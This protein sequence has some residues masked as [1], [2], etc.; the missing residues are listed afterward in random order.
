VKKDK[1]KGGTKMNTDTF[2][3]V[4]TSLFLSKTVL[5]EN[6]LQNVLQNWKESDERFA[7]FV[8]ANN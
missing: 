6:V 8:I 2:L 1:E 4:K 3:P 5:N 7:H